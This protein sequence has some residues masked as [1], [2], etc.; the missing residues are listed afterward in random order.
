MMADGIRPT[1]ALRHAGPPVRIL[2]SDAY[3]YAM[4][5]GHTLSLKVNPRYRSPAMQSISRAA[6]SIAERASRR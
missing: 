5:Q 6:V 1:A 2:G 4:K 3:S